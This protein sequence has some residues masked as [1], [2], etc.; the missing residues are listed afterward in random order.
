MK[1]KEFIYTFISFSQLIAIYTWNAKKHENE[2]IFFGE[3]F[4]LIGEKWTNRFTV[5]FIKPNTVD[6]YQHTRLDIYGFEVRK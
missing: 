6:S 2:L 3:A 1:L 4:A 5:N